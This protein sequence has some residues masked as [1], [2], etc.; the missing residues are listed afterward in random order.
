ME[1]ARSPRVA[2]ESFYV[3]VGSSG[4]AL[5]G[6]QFVVIAPIAEARRQS[7]AQEVSAF[8]TERA[9]N[10]RVPFGGAESVWV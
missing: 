3:I 4:G 1:A 9:I 5:T 8:G 10:F 7:T 2:W 6:L